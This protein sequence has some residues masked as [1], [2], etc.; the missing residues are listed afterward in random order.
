EGESSVQNQG[1][2]SVDLKK[3]GLCLVPMSMVTNFLG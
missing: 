2:L 1:G 3:K